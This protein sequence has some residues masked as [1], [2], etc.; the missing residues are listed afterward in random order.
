MEG[1]RKTV[2][3]LFA[4]IKGSME[5][6]EDIDPEEARAIVDPAIKLMIDAAHRYDGYIVQSTGDG[7]FAIF[8]AQVA[9]EDH[10]QRALCAALRIQDEMQRY[11]AR[12]REQGHLPLEARV[13]V[14]TGEVVVRSI[15]TDEKHVEYTPIGHSIS[16]ASRMQALAPSGSIA[17]TEQLR[18]LCEGYFLFKPLGPTRVKGVTE[19]VQV[20]EVTGVGP[21]RTPL[22]RA[23]R[24]GLTKFVGRSP[25]MEAMAHAA[26]LAKTGRGQSVAAVAEAGIGKSRLFHEFRARHQSGWS[27]VEA[28]SF[29]HGKASI[30]L[31]VIGMLNT[32]FGI[33]SSD[34]TRKRREKVNGKILTLDRA[35]EDTLPYLYSLLELSEGDDPLAQM[36]GQ[37][38]RRRTLDAIRRIV[39]RESINQPLMVIFEDLHLIDA[40]TQALLN[41]LTESIGTSKVL[42][43]LNYRPEYR[44]EWGTQSSYTQLRLQPLVGESAAEM[45]TALLGDSV[46]MQPLRRL[47]MESTGGNPNFIEETILELFRGRRAGSE[48]AGEGDAAGQSVAYPDDGPGDTGVANRSAGGRLNGS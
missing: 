34:D 30:Y 45:L 31:P 32:Y 37:T 7:V 35:L 27:V 2:T 11:A 13:G 38:R 48:R 39:I 41:L 8:G 20:Y 5:L 24:R 9:H 18:K 46:E 36:D 33:D 23:A 16:L 4:D 43:L 19:Q 29:S 26:E 40:E 6:M 1:E 10:P 15:R 3:A 17:T 22:Q 47:V 25:E 12:L 44:H 14:N 21:L 28:T 42:M